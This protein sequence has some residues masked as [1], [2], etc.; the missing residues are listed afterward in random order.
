[1]TTHILVIWCDRCGHLRP[2]HPASWLCHDCHNGAR[3]A[4]QD[5]AQ[6]DRNRPIG[7]IIETMERRAA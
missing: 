4:E 1:V 6:Q 7:R 2:T 5:D 3:R